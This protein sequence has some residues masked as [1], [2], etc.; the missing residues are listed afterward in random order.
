MKPPAGPKR[1]KILQTEKYEL[2]EWK[3]S[4]S[5]FL[6]TLGKVCDSYEEF[7]SQ[8]SARHFVYLVSSIPQ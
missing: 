8:K 3:H 1:A 2:E 7:V 4:F 5:P 6:L